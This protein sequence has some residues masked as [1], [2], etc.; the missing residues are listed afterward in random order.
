VASLRQIGMPL[1]RIQAIIG[2][3]PVGPRLQ[4]RVT[5]G[6]DGEYAIPLR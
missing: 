3:D 5:D 4:P 1:A 6:P 2:G